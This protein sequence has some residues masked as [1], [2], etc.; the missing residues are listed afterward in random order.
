MFSKQ[1]QQQSTLKKLPALCCKEAFIFS[2]FIMGCVYSVP[3]DKIAIVTRCGAFDRLATP[4][5]LC[6]PVPC[7]YQK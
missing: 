1:T 7:I 3:N 4:G 6:L 5:L 2:K